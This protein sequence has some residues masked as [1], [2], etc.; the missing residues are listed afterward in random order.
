MT[1]GKFFAIQI[2]NKTREFNS[3]AYKTCTNSGS[4][5]AL[6]EGYPFLPL[7]ATAWQRETPFFP[8][9]RA[10]LETSISTVAKH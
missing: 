1:E 5:D 9:W 2:S 7:N 4:P 3:S 10:R 8:F 6:P